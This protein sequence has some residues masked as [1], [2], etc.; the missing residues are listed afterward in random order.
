MVYGVNYFKNTQEL[1][2]WFNSNYSMLIKKYAEM[3]Q[4]SLKLTNQIRKSIAYH[5]IQDEAINE[6]YSLNECQINKLIL[7]LM[8]GP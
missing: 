3:I 5:I 7:L 1:V 6:G 4:N 8:E 2:M